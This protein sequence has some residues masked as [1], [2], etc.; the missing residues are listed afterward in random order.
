[1]R[2]APDADSRHAQVMAALE[3]AHPYDVADL[4]FDYRQP[5][6]RCRLR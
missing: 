5:A 2:P 3:G 1:M 4:A 6:P